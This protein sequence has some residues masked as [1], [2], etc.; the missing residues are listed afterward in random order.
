MGESKAEI[1][2]RARQQI[3]QK[4]LEDPVKRE[5]FQKY[6]AITGP[7]LDELAKLGYEIDTL[8]DLRHQGK[9]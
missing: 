4:A 9:P 3:K 8:D 1:V 2:E 5:Q 7:L 6:L